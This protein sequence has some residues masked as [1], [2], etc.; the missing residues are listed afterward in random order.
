MLEE[1]S[2]LH[3]IQ[4]WL[5]MLIFARSTA[6]GAIRVVDAARPDLGKEAHGKLLMDCKVTRYV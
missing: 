2:L 3:F 1:V 4:I 5:Y 6:Q